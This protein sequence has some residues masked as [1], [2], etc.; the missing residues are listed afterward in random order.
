MIRK[1]NKSALRILETRTDVYILYKLYIIVYTTVKI[2]IYI[3][4]SV[5]AL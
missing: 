4:F 1:Y 3:I 5:Y 2:P